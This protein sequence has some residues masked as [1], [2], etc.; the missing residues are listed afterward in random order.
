M[1]MTITVLNSISDHMVVVGIYN[2]FISYLF[3][4]TFAF[5]KHL[6]WLRLFTW[7]SDSSIHSWRVWDISSL[8]W[9]GLF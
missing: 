2:T 1:L 8:A 5:H 4:I 7:Q 3:W 9:I 6:N